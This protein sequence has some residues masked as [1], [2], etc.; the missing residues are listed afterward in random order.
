MIFMPGF[1]GVDGMSGGYAISFVSFFGVIV[2]AIVVLVYN[3]L[4]SRFDAI[5]GGMEVLARWTYPSELWKKYS[6][7]E[8]EESVA[9]VKP[10][11]ILTSAMCLIAGVGAVLWDP[12]PGIYVL[13]IMVF[14]IILMGLAAFLTRR[15]LHHDNL[16]SLGE[17]II[18]KKAV[19]LN[20]RLFYWDYFGSK[21]EKVELRKDKDYSVLI[22]TTWAP[23]MQ[24]GQSY[25]LRV[26]VPPGE[27]ARA[28]EIASTMKTD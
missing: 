16:R 6:D 5:V 7:A 1:L 9:E 28:S 27:E 4:S 3:G 25:S 8:Y 15:H 18:S 17:A 10:L 19:L 2:G 23:T 24:F 20:N 13:G 21:L 26:P 11:F 14:T 22:F 12:E